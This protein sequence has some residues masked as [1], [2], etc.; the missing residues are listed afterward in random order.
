MFRRLLRLAQEA[1][2]QLRRMLRRSLEHCEVCRRASWWRWWRDLKLW[3]GRVHRL[4]DLQ[5]SILYWHRGEHLM[6][7]VHARLLAIVR[8][9]VP[10]HAWSLHAW[11]ACLLAL[12]LLLLLLRLLPPLLALLLLRVALQLQLLSAL[13]LL[14]ASSKQVLH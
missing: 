1:R 7:R 2:W 3:L 8:Y 12:L 9:S 4:L 14:R 5:R 11:T 13:G 10:K 6:A